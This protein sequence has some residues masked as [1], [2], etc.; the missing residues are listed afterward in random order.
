MVEEVSIEEEE[1]EAEVIEKANPKTIVQAPE[2]EVEEVVTIEITRILTEDLVMEEAVAVEDPVGDQVTGFVHHVTT[3]T[4]PIAEN[5]T[6]AEQK[7]PLVMA[8]QSTATPEA[9][10]VDSGNEIEVGTEI[11]KKIEIMVEEIPVKT[12]T[13]IRT[14][15]LEVA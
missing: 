6:D 3:T 14:D 1:E 7:N 13:E 11:E 8:I 15:L 9:A 4:L 10:A 2:T 5:A 12:I